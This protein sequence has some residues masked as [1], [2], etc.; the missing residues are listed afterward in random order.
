[1]MR[2]SNLSY[3]S[4]VLVRNRDQ[5]IDFPVCAGVTL[6]R[7]F[8]VQQRR[9]RFGLNFERC[10]FSHQILD[11]CWNFY[12]PISLSIRI[13]IFLPV[14]RS[15][16]FEVHCSRTAWLIK[17]IFEMMFIDAVNSRFMFTFLWSDQSI[18][19]DIDFSACVSVT[20]FRGSLLNNGATD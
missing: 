5:D 13:S 10:L 8:S 16:F 1:M 7:G 15:R 18:D 2:R 11:L 17:F 14:C 9:D 19:Q 12:D 4:S 3:I 20:L 6:S